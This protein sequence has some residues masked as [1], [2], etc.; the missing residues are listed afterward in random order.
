MLK[1]H[2]M[3]SKKGKLGEFTIEPLVSTSFKVVYALDSS[4]SKSVSSEGNYITIKPQVEETNGFSCKKNIQVTSSSQLST[5][6]KGKI[7]GASLKLNSGSKNTT[8]FFKKAHDGYFSA[9]FSSL[10]SSPI[11]IQE[12]MLKPNAFG[13]MSDLDFIIQMMAR[14]IFGE[15][16]ELC[17]GDQVMKSVWRQL[18]TL[19]KHRD[20]SNV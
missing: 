15:N 19:L 3:K 7:N 14:K 10:G 8:V 1:L 9:T 18:R 4:D 11:Y 20:K 6:T 17:A 16:I 5:T 12:G 2:T 13:I